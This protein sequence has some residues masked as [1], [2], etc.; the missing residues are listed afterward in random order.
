MRTHARAHIRYNVVYST[1]NTN[2]IQ[3][4]RHGSTRC[5]H[6]QFTEE[7]RNLCLQWN[8]LT[9]NERENQTNRVQCFWNVNVK[10]AT[11]DQVFGFSVLWNV[12]TKWVKNVDRGIF[13]RKTRMKWQWQGCERQV[14]EC[15]HEKSMKCD[16][17]LHIPAHFTAFMAEHTTFQKKKI[18]IFSM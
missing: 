9:V 1:W 11:D 16:Y 4:I 8:T 14:A 12:N 17:Q 3:S 6:I 13:S 2:T 15:I 18:T 10:E 7:R 5:C